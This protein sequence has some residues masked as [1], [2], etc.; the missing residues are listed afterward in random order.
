MMQENRPQ[1]LFCSDRADLQPSRKSLRI[2]LHPKKSAE[3]A[4]YIRL[5]QRPRNTANSKSNKG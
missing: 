4:K 3:G 1:T 5:G 2:D